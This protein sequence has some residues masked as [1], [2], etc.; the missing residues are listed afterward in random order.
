MTPPS[1]RNP[2]NTD[3]NIHPHPLPTLILET[4]HPVLV[5][6]PVRAGRRMHAP[7]S[8]SARSSQPNSAVLARIIALHTRGRRSVLYDGAIDAEL[9]LRRRVLA[10]RRL[11][12]ERFQDLVDDGGVPAG[13]GGVDVGWLRG[14]GGV[15]GVGRN[16]S[17]PCL[18]EGLA[19][20]C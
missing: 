4:P 10:G 16:L 14:E 8:A 6:V 3:H 2:H 1:N 7:P 13:C 9:E 15:A 20:K 18:G 19:M 11:A 5:I 12:D 17:E